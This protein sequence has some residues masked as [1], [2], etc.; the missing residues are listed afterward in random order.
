MAPVAARGAAG[1][2]GDLGAALAVARAQRAKAWELRAAT[3]L[4]R[5]LAERGKRRQAQQLL[6]SVCGSFRDGCHTRDLRDARALLTERTIR[7]PSA[8]HP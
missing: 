5:L 4:A 2:Q 7:P 1:T 8:A 6:A 3:S